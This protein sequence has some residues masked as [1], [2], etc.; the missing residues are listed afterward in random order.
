MFHESDDRKRARRRGRQPPTTR[1]EEAYSARHP[2][3][4]SRDRIELPNVMPVT[5]RRPSALSAR[6]APSTN[7]RIVSSGIRRRT[8]GATLR[9]TTQERAGSETAPRVW[10]PTG[11]GPHD[12]VS[13]DSCLVAH[14][15]LE[16]LVVEG[17]Y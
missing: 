17:R 2:S 8:N 6:A 13:V 15:A 7:V 5:Q 11:G 4:T 16:E 12:P 9:A 3:R 14:P 10:C 1:G